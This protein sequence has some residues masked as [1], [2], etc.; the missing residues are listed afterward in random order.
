MDMMT[1][2]GHLIARSVGLDTTC[3]RHGDPNLN[4]PTVKHPV[5]N[6][7]G[8]GDVM[9]LHVTMSRVIPF[10]EFRMIT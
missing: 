2:E 8:S 4:D 3:S 6:P 7:S 1:R 9:R 10:P 5:G